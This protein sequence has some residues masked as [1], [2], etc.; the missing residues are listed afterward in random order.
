LT[1]PPGEQRHIQE[2]HF[3]TALTV[4]RH[5]AKRINKHPCSSSP[6]KRATGYESPW[7]SLSGVLPV[8]QAPAHLQFGA[9]FARYFAKEIK[10]SFSL[11]T[12]SELNLKRRKPF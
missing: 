3:A 4:Q 2:L 10:K 7:S 1:L 5:R 11:L 9:F 8:N 6:Q 12:A